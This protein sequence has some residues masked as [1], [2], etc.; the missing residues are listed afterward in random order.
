MNDIVAAKLL[1]SYTPPA[2]DATPEWADVLKRAEITRAPL[3]PVAS[4]G[5]S[6]VTPPRRKFRRSLLLVAAALAGIV[7]VATVTPAR[8]TISRTLGDFS[9]WL[10]GLPG[11][12]APPHDQAALNR[13]T[14]SWLDFPNGTQLHRLLETKVDGVTLALDGFRVGDSLCLQI[15]ATGAVSG[16]DQSCAP[17]S[18]LRAQKAPALVVLTDAAFGTIGGKHV[19]IGPYVYT[20]SVR[21]DVT[22]GIVA[23]GVDHVE[24]AGTSGGRRKALVESDAFLAVADRPPIGYRTNQAWASAGGKRVALDL[25]EAPF[26]Q[27]NATPPKPRRPLGPTSIQRHVVGGTIGWL[28]RQEPRGAPVPATGPF[29]RLGRGPFVRSVLFQRLIAPDPNS[30]RASSSSS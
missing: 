24:I 25:A 26:D 5:A 14:R 21:V 12:K 2:L 8:S 17:L 9:A 30:P 11:T 13:A 15:I 22:I 1:E 3:T 29:A 19:Q 7:V 10:T 18:Q 28:T 6:P 16:S 4:I 23:D 20:H 27:L